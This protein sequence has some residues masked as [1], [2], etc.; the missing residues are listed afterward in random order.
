VEVATTT[1]YLLFYSTLGN[2]P[3]NRVSAITFATLSRF[4]E[5]TRFLNPGKE[6]RNRVSAITFA[7]LTSLSKETRLIDVFEL[8]NSPK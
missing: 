2:P 3:R 6:P 4:D 1:G 5:E 8:G 7:T